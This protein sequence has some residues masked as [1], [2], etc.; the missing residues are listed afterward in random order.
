MHRLNPSAALTR[1]AQLW[2]VT[3]L[4]GHWLFATY[5]IFH[6]GGVA[7][8]SGINAMGETR[9]HYKDNDTIGNFAVLAHVFVAIIIHGFGPLQF[10][11]DLRR[12]FPKFHR[13]IGKAFLAAV[14]IASVSGLYF[15]FI[16]GTRD[17]WIGDATNVLDAAL[18]FVFGFLALR[19]AVQR[20]FKT[21]RR[22]ALRLFMAAS[23][24]WFVRLGVY[25]TRTI[26]DLFGIGFKGIAQT[27]FDG[28]HIAKLLLPLGLLELYLW[29]QRRNDPKLRIAAAIAITVGT[30][31]T[32]VGIYAIAKARW[33]ETIFG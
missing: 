32:G 31:A 33:L 29:A 30:A 21:H 2:F 13:W 4:F 6:Y 3:A 18:I 20:D 25:G 24:V 11:P 19:A 27:V 10:V 23:A 15:V 28:A 16:R 26:T 14:S 8:S 7:V 1:S 9:L 12:R 17:N 22:W 5:I